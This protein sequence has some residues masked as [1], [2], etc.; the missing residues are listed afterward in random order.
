MQFFQISLAHKL[1]YE[2]CDTTFHSVSQAVIINSNSFLSKAKS[3][4]IRVTFLSNYMKKK[5]EIK[6]AN[7]ERKVYST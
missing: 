4:L 1:L 5:K 3:R 6:G 2:V 7:E